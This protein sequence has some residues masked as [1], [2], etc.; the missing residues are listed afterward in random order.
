MHGGTVREGGGERRGS[1]ISQLTSTLA[2]S[3]TVLTPRLAVD[4]NEADASIDLR[5]VEFT[6]KTAKRANE[7][8]DRV[9][10]LG[11]D[12]KRGGRWGREEGGEGGG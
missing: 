4:G 6:R 1:S 12:I 5:I 3:S 11:I 10:P 8:S 9:C 2:S 7:T